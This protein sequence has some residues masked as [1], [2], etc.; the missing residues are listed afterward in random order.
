MIS[1]SLENTRG[2][3]SVGDIVGSIEEAEVDGVQERQVLI[4]VL[5]LIIPGAPRE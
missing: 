5:T 4:I 3:G 1:L 2:V